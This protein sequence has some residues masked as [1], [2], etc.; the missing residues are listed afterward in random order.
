MISMISIKFRSRNSYQSDSLFELFL[1]LVASVIS[2]MALT[3][4]PIFQL[5]EWY[6]LISELMD[7]ASSSEVMDHRANT[8]LAHANSET[9]DTAVVAIG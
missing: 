3:A 1:L 7:E 5:P 6:C 8:S 4:I 9:A 2:H